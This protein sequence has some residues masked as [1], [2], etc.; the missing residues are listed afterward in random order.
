MHKVTIIINT[1]SAVKLY[2]TVLSVGSV[3]YDTILKLLGPTQH[4]L[5]AGGPGSIPDRTIRTLTF[6]NYIWS[7]FW[8]ALM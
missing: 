3:M 6:L 5:D 2:I 4:F 1:H 8:V 7:V